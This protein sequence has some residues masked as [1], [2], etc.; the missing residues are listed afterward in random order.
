MDKAIFVDASDILAISRQGQ[1]E[2]FVAGV[3]ITFGAFV[4]S[5][6]L[7]T[8]VHNHIGGEVVFNDNRK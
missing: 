8:M 4:M 3:I 7:R 2:G 5:K 1:K 6:R